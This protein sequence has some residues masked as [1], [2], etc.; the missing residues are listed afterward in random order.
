MS[1]S[2]KHVGAKFDFSSVSLPFSAAILQ[3]ES[4]Y[5]LFFPICSLE[6][7]QQMRNHCIWGRV[8]GDFSLK[9]LY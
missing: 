4:F 6:S 3:P 8:L 9:I 7:K 2:Q 1:L 5:P